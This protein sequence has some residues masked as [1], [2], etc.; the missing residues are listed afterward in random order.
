MA[1]IERIFGKSP[2]GPL[3]EHMVVV[4]ECVDHIIPFF[5][6]VIKNDKSSIKAIADK[7]FDLEEKADEIKNNLRDHLPRSLFMPVDRH[8]ILEILD[9]QDSIAD[10]AQDISTLF[11]LRPFAIP[12]KVKN[13]LRVFVDSSVKVCYMGA[14]ISECIDKLLDTSFLGT[15]AERVLGMIKELNK[16]ERKNDEA[17]LRLARQIFSIEKDIPPVEIFLW[18]QLN[19][20]IGNIAD[21]SQKVANRMRL[22]IAK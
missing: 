17:G 20:L 7:I 12:E 10:T 13:G 6:A 9:D 8:N 4:K 3:Q 11:T 1:T 19:G 14:E 2:F 16:L 15:E 18:F 5:E 22:I 21:Y